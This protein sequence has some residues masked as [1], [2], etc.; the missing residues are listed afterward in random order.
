[1]ASYPRSG[2]PRTKDGSRRKILNGTWAFKLKCLPDGTASK[3]KARYCVQGDQQTD[4]VNYFETYAAVVQWSTVRLLL[5]MILANDW[6]TRQ[7][8]YTNAFGQATLK[9][10]VYIE[11][12][13]G[14]GF[15]DKKDKVLH[16][17]KSLYGLKQ[18]PRT[19]FEMLR[20]GLLERGFVQSE[21]DMCLFMKKDMICVVYVDDTILAGPDAADLEKE[22]K[23]LGVR[24][25][26]KCYKFK[27]RK[28]Q[29]EISWHSHQE[30]KVTC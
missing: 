23:G 29:L 19:F 9:E 6:T 12:P 1:M 14:Y 7:V 3:Y 28:E 20:T 24:D 4:G 17:I 25:E 2:V 13:R 21:H 15:K 11:A 10:E 5:T 16:L 30:I 26:E 27:L 22:I 18:A 8:D